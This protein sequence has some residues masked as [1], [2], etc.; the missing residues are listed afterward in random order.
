MPKYLAIALFAL[1]NDLIHAWGLDRQLGYCAQVT[2]IL[3][4]YFCFAS[5]PLVSCRVC[6]Y[7]FSFRVT[8]HK[9]LALSMPNTS[10][11]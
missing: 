9:K 4:H 10:F 2:S 5:K 1:Q 11:I 3:H 7:G 6:D 8:E